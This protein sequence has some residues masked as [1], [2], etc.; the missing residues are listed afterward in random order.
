MILPTSL[1]S[2]DKAT[3]TLSAMASDGPLHRH[4]LP[5]K[6]IPEVMGIQ[7]ERTGV[8]INVEYLSKRIANE[9]LESW[10][11]YNHD[12]DISVVIFND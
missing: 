2:Y 1:F 9:E 4:F 7:S 8:I 12:N 6:M 10:T 3:R 11:Y 5:G